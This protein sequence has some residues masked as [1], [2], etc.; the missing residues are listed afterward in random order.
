MTVVDAVL[1]GAQRE[2]RI[3]ADFATSPRGPFETVD[4]MVKTVRT[5]ARDAARSVGF[6]PLHGMHG[7]S[8]GSRVKPLMKIPSKLLRGQNVL[9]QTIRRLP[10][11]KIGRNFRR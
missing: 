7:M 10:I 2:A 6:S 11:G 4:M 8:L 9:G 5:T 1:R 3:M